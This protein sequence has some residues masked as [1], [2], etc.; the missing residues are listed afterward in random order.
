MSE[1][2]LPLDLYR[3]APHPCGYLPDREARSLLVDPSAR[4]SPQLYSQLLA[5]GFRRSG[6]HVYR[7]WCDGCRRCVA[8]RVPVAHFSPA[9]RQRRTARRNQDLVAQPVPAAFRDEHYR[10]YQAYTAARHG[11]GEMAH[12]D[13]EAYLS[14]LTAD[15]QDT[16]FLELR[17]A[18]QLV[19]VAVTDQLA[20]SL[21]AVYTFFDPRLA[22]RSL[23]VE[24]VLRQIA[25]AAAQ[26]LE[27]LYLGYW[28]DGC[29]KMAY[30]ADY[31]PLELLTEAG[32]RR[33]GRGEEMEVRG[34]RS[35]GR[36]EWSG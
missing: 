22:L 4:L 6:S 31:R 29:R 14:F 27:W 34:P 10:L 28:I 2:R 35:E 32:W 11:D 7:P 21:S 23:G 15:W 26:G 36:G 24:A 30:K 17:H 5:R 33:V 8:V 18:G 25:W 19:A 9:R 20:D 1:S 16:A 3:T 13:P 12:A